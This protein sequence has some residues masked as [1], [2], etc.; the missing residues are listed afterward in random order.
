MAKSQ[1]FIPEKILIITV[2]SVHILHGKMADVSKNTNTKA[3]ANGNDSKSSS[4]NNT[5]GDIGNAP[6]IDYDLG[7]MACFINEDDPKLRYTIYLALALIDF[8]VFS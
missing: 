8:V 5:V 7:N 3:N 6:I 1:P 4:N 2:I